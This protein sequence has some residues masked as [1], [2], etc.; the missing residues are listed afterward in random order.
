MGLFINAI[1]LSFM[2]IKAMA[3]RA[4]ASAMLFSMKVLI[5]RTFSQNDFRH[6]LENIS[7]TI[8][9]RSHNLEEFTPSHCHVS[10]RTENTFNTDNFD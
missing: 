10:S 8:V 7:S 4:R 1:A 6:L 2:H 5:F 9:T 3:I